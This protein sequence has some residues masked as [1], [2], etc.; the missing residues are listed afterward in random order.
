M[1]IQT[2]IVILIIVAAFVYAG[3]AVRHKISAFKPKDNSCGADCGC[4][5]KSK[6]KI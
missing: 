5:S 4:E 3:N 2:V 6:V 1:D